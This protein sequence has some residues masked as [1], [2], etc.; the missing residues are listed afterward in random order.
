MTN[1]LKTRRPGNDI[2]ARL[3]RQAAKQ[4]HRTMKGVVSIID[5]IY[6]TRA[7]VFH[8]ISKHREESLNFDAHRVFDTSSQSKRKLRKKS[9]GKIVKIYAN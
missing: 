9:R 7:T 6:Q 4:Q 2:S 1:F 8:R 3:Q 5:V